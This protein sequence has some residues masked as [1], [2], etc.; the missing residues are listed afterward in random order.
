MGMVCVAAV[1]WDCDLRQN[2]YRSDV[3]GLVGASAVLDY[4]DYPEDASHASAREYVL[5]AEG[6]SDGCLSLGLVE[7]EIL[8][9]SGQKDGDDANLLSRVHLQAGDSKYRENQEIEVAEDVH[10]T[11][12]DIQGGHFVRTCYKLGPPGKAKEDAYH[13][14]GEM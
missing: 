8:Q 9:R 3:P 5:I 2:Q 14:A 11:E 4:V 7:G 1:D 12:D 13:R 6:K 10:S